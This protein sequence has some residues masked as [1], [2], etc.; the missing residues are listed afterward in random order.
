SCSEDP[1][2][3]HNILKKSVGGGGGEFGLNIFYY[4]TNSLLHDVQCYMDQDL[5]KS[6]S[7]YESS[8]EYT[9]LWRQNVNDEWHK[10][11]LSALGSKQYNINT[12]R[13]LV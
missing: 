3:P 2:K 6:L 10:T 11:I 4:E 7:L 8:P 1:C 13:I 12:M 9:I 5:I